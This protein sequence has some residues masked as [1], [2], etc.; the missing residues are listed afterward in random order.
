MISSALSYPGATAGIASR[1]H[2]A[3]HMAVFL[4]I[5]IM[6]KETMFKDQKKRWRGEGNVERRN[7]RQ[8]LSRRNLG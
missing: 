2:V 5:W 4:S 1:A 7:S 6:T 8:K 3:V